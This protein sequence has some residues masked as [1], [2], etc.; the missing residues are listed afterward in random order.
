MA[1]LTVQGTSYTL[2]WGKVSFSGPV[3]DDGSFSGHIAASAPPAK[4][5][6]AANL[7]GIDLIN[8]K[9]VGNSATGEVHL[10]KCV[11][12]LDLTKSG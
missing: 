8:G 12:T 6:K 10:I 1:T 3:A 5:H 7:A 9:I 4:Q 2:P 11:G